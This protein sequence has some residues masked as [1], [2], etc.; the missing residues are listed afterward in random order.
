MFTLSVNNKKL[1]DY[2]LAVKSVNRPLLPARKYD[3]IDLQEQDGEILDVF[4]YKNREISVHI[5]FIE[6][7]IEDIRAKA[8]EVAYLLR[9]KSKLVFSDEPDKYYYGILLDQSDLEVLGTVGESELTFLCDPFAYGLQKQT[10]T[11]SIGHNRD[12]EYQG[13]AHT[14]TRIILRNT[15]TE[16]IRNIRIKQIKKGD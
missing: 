7:N 15:G 5:Y 12:I 11:L 4:G 8:R 14:P 9:K 13:T 16:T 10:K 6:K 2:G 1:S 3:E